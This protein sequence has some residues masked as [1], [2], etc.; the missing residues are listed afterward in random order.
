MEKRRQG[1][2]KNLLSRDF[3]YSDEEDEGGGGG[4]HHNGTHTSTGSPIT[5]S[6]VSKEKL[7]NLARSVVAEPA[8]QEEMR[9]LVACVNKDV[10][11]GSPAAKMALPQQQLQQPLTF[12]MPNFSFPPPSFSNGTL[13]P[14]LQLRP[15]LIFKL[16]RLQC[17]PCQRSNFH[18]NNN[19]RIGTIEKR[20]KTIAMIETIILE[21]TEGIAVLVG[22]HGNGVDDDR[23]R[24]SDKEKD[25]EQMMRDRRRMGLPEKLK[26][27]HVLIASRTLWFGRI[28]TSANE[29]DIIESVK[30]IGTPEKI[31]IVNTRGCAY[32]T[33]P[34]RKLAFKIIDRMGK[35]IQVLKKNIKLAWATIPSIK[36]EQKFMDK[37]DCE[38]GFA[39]IP[40]SILPDGNLDKLMEGAWLELYTLPE[41]LKDRY[42]NTGIKQIQQQLQAI[43]LPPAGLTL[44]PPQMAAGLPATAGQ[45]MPGFTFVR[46]FKVFKINIEFYFSKKFF[47]T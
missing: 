17:S 3:D 20:L 32:V 41:L 16:H 23:E 19:K 30:E 35:T 29:N 38:L 26:F 10:G 13:F 44:L 45:L 7:L 12:P 6:S 25:R 28:P 40:F 47:I 2:I 22:L 42:T 15:L 27:E 31:I 1:N 4:H 11:I 18:N 36:E 33:M 34:D 39:E 21:V 37:W 5:L 8:H 9:K 46:F 14:G 24:N 43:Q